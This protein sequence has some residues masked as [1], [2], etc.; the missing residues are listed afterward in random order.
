MAATF[1]FTVTEAPAAPSGG[2]DELTAEQQNG[3]TALRDMALD[4]TTG[5]LMLDQ[6]D[7]VFNRG[8]EAI[9]SDIKSRC[10][11]FG[12]GVVPDDGEEIPGEWFLDTS[13]GVNYWGKVFRGA[14]AEA[15]ARDAFVQEIA[16]TPGVLEVRRVV[17]SITDREFEL[18]FDVLTDLGMVISATL[19]EVLGAAA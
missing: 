16:K 1:I 6:G 15:D 18:R 8:V 4:P 3:A 17:S 11:T 12:P 5:D 19:T 14:V 2:D 9:A 10:L 13:I 7:I